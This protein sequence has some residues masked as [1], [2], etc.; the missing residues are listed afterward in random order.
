MKFSLVAA[1]AV[2]Q[3]ASAHYSFDVTVH[4]DKESR[5]NE[6]IRLNTR[7]AKYNPTKWK[8]T[9]DDMTPDMTDFRCNKGAFSS[10][11]NTKVLEVKAGDKLAMKLAV[12]ATMQ[13]PGPAFV[14]MS[15]APG[16]VVDYEGD[17]GW[18]KIHQEGICKPGADIKKEAWCTW[19]KDRISFTIPEGTPLGEYLVRAEHVGVHGAHDGQAEFYYAC[20]QVKVVQGGNGTPGPMIKFPGGYKKDDPSWNFSVWGGYKDYPFPEPAVWN[21]GSSGGN[22]T[23]TPSETPA[24]SP[25]Q[26]AESPA[27]SPAQPE[28]PAQSPSQGSPAQGS[29]AQGS[30]AQDAPA[31]DSNDYNTQPPAQGSPAED[32]DYPTET[33]SDNTQTPSGNTQTPSGNTQPPAGGAAV[34]HTK[35]NC[36][37][38]KKSRRGRRAFRNSLRK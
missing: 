6:F 19:D 15:K 31:D 5:P 14:Y 23:E 37:G 35:E 10:A 12:G 13:H 33:P 30:P 18:F 38:G 32:N 28:S 16:K 34:P 17:L 25:S 9:R 1:L 2:A 26:P 8:N 7:P 3:L 21:G 22:S 29:P 36:K 20:A 24:T 4:N 27:A 11:K